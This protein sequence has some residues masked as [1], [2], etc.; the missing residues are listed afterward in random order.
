VDDDAL[1]VTV[2]GDV[3]T[4][5]WDYGVVIPLWTDWDGLLPA[6]PEWLRTALGLSDSLIHDLS[7]W[8][9][10][11]GHL[12]ADPPLRTAQAYRHLD[13]QARELVVR[14]R[15]EVGSRFT[16]TYKPW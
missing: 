7:T 16:V 12:D 15:Q 10:A 14:L 5:M 9:T 3:I 4:F 8:G 6:E 11:M 1:D 2:S 13:Q